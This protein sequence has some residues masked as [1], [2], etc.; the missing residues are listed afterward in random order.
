MLR[1]QH[2]ENIQKLHRNIFILGRIPEE[3][4]QRHLRTAHVCP[5]P[6]DAKDKL[7]GGARLKALECLAHGKVVITTSAGVEG[8]S[9]AI[10]GVNMIIVDNFKDFEKRMIE[11]LKHPERYEQLRRNATQLAKNYGWKN[12]L[13]PYLKIIEKV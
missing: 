2:L 12:V 4:K 6:F 11:V 8:I 1:E 3:E 9:G 7:M 13:S 10:D 5:L